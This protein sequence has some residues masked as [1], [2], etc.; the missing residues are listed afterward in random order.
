MLV[1]L[2]LC[3]ILSAHTPHHVIGAQK[4]GGVW[5]IW[6]K[7]N[8]AR[9]FIMKNHPTIRY[10]DRNIE[11][12]ED[13]PFN[14]PHVPSEKIV[15]RDLPLDF[16][17]DDVIKH[18]EDNYPHIVIRSDVI[19]SRIPSRDNNLTSFYNGDRIIYV[20]EGFFPVLPEDTS[21]SG[22]PCKVWHPNQKIF[23]ERCC[24]ETHRTFDTNKCDSFCATPN[25][26][27]FKFNN[28]PLSNF[29]PCTVNV[30]DRKWT[31][32]EHA[33]QWAKLSAINRPE[34]AEGV[35]KATSA[36]SAKY[37]A[38]QVPIRDL[39]EWTNDRK[40]SV[41][42]EILEAKSV[43]CQEFK[44]SLLKGRGKHFIEGTKHSMFWGAG[45]SYAHA[46][47][48]NPDKLIG[49]NHLGRLLNELR[50]QLVSNDVTE[51][52]EGASHNTDIMTSPELPVQTVITEHTTISSPH[53]QAPHDEQV[54][55][56]TQCVAQTISAT[57]PDPRSVPPHPKNR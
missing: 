52:S 21:I 4:K 36:A 10:N 24:D 13:N 56:V 19:R 22:A 17:G 37:I 20:K 14:R 47:N 26:V 9:D 39:A 11:L 57:P 12:H 46:R 28:D 51:S 45:L 8:E 2:D 16:P 55:T 6:M 5:I 50:D 29:Y 53:S 38:D 25:S 43:S 41:M 35:I 34:L 1:D 49:D 33:Y 7:T 54:T 23:C 31:S 42:K 3:D 40:I 30:F 27:V 15:F 48:T 44:Q 32:S 18:L